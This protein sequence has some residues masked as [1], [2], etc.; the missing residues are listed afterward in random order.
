MT[1]IRRERQGCNSRKEIRFA[2]Q[3]RY[4][5]IQWHEN[6]SIT[7][8]ILEPGR[9]ELCID[10]CVFASRIEFARGKIH[11]VAFANIAESRDGL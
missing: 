6:C 10:P 1:F 9:R 5:I 7:N 2:A 8:S 11:S 4:R 3:Y